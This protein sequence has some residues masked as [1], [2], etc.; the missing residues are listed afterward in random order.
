MNYPKL[1]WSIAAADFVCPDGVDFSDFAVFSLAWLS[2]DTP[3]G[4]WDPECDIS[5]P[6]DGIIDEFDLDVFID[7]WL[8]GF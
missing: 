3:T 2:D 6:A 5:E 8:T 4:N 7:N 1:A